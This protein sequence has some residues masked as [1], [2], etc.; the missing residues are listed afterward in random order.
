MELET[1]EAMTDKIQEIQDQ[2]E[3]LP[4]TLADEVISLTNGTTIGSALSSQRDDLIAEFERVGH[5]N[6]GQRAQQIAFFAQ[7]LEGKVHHQA[8]FGS[9]LSALDLVLD[10][11]DGDEV[12]FTEACNRIGP[13][14]AA[15]GPHGE[16]LNVSGQYLK[17][18]H[19]EVHRADAAQAHNVK[20]GQYDLTREVRAVLED[21]GTEP[22]VRQH[23]IDLYKRVTGMDI[24]THHD[25]PESLHE[26]E[27]QVAELGGVVRVQNLYNQVND[28]IGHDS[29]SAEAETGESFLTDRSITEDYRSLISGSDTTDE[30]A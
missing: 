23:Y 16:P 28:N 13:A 3:A 7:N 10:E 21:E 29:A 26:L 25:L 12:A 1:L 18:D 8:H 15:I 6:A 27:D 30:A 17:S 4:I 24:E 2:Y 20:P 11:I 9:M 22:E 19:A 5:R 14:I